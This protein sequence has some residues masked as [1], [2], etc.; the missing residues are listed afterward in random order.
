MSSLSRLGVAWRTGEISVPTCQAGNRNCSQAESVWQ[1]SLSG[2]P[3]PLVP[4]FLL[5]ALTPIL[6][7][8]LSTE[9]LRVVFFINSGLRKTKASKGRVLQAT[10]ALGHT[11][12]AARKQP[13]CFHRLGQRETQVGK[14]MTNDVDP[15]YFRKLSVTDF[16]SVPRFVWIHSSAVSL[17]LPKTESDHPCVCILSPARPI[18]QL[19][20]RP[21]D[22]V[23]I[24]EKVSVLGLLF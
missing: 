15:L 20:Q 11:R 3:P 13:G 1:L 17:M 2:V 10:S 7:T 12:T 19:F 8:W 6:S 21:V 18:F 22:L 23:S 9:A 24:I 4:L 5:P 14:K 16:A